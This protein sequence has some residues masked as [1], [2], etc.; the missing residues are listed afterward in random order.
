[1][2]NNI[3][4]DQAVQKIFKRRGKVGRDLPSI[5]PATVSLNR[6]KDVAII[7]KV[8]CNADVVVTHNDSN[9]AASCSSIVSCNNAVLVI[10]SLS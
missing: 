7:R 3:H 4:I 6:R 2:N 8:I 9:T 1:M 10:W 5:L